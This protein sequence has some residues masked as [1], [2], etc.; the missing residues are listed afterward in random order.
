MQIYPVI[1]PVLLACLLCGCSSPPTLPEPK[2]N[3]IPAN[4]E[5]PLSVLSEHVTPVNAVVVSPTLSR[6]RFTGH[7]HP[8]SLVSQGGKRMTL[9]SALQRILPSGWTTVFS[10]EVAKTFNGRVSWRG[11]DLWPHVLQQVLYA[12]DLQA[13]VDWD[14]RQAEITYV[15]QRAGK[16][17]TPLRA[18]QTEK[19]AASVVTPQAV[20]P[21]LH[22]AVVTPAAEKSLRR[23]TAP[24]PDRAVK[25]PRPEPDAVWRSEVGST[26]KD[27]L[28]RWSATEAC[29]AGG[30]WRVI[31]ETP[32][33]YR[34]DAPL[35]FSGRFMTAM[36]GI[37]SLYQHA[38]KPLYAVTSQS[39]CLI[40]ITDK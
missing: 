35:Q 34:T 20:T 11:G 40:R 17:A 1:S 14:R 28:F 18:T 5:A 23:Q 10:D 37:L 7:A 4:P 6:V 15:K 29:P 27:T 9:A 21:P 13:R 36:E 16:A 2:G 22:Q 3:F 25:T 12:H 30:Y 26:L 38:Q 39:Q 31:W 19:P 8:L 33:N 32:V 24:E